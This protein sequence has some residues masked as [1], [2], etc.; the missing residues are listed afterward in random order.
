MSAQRMVEHNQNEMRTLENSP[1]IHFKRR[2]D[3]ILQESENAFKIKQ[4]EELRDRIENGTFTASLSELRSYLSEIDEGI[5]GFV[6]DP[7]KE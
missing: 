6:P 7:N 1:L 3:A 5:F 4:F 2:V